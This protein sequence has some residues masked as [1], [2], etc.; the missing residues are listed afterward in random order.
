MQNKKQKKEKEGLLKS[1]SEAEIRE[2]G[3]KVLLALKPIAIKS[4]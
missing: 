4:F 2:L 1:L 3:G